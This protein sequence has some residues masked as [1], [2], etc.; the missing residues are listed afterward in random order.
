[1]WGMD[2]LFSKG[3]RSLQLFVAVP[4]GLAFIIPSLSN[5]PPFRADR[6]EELVVAVFEQME[7]GDKF[8]IHEMSGWSWVFYAR[9]IPRGNVRYGRCRRGDPR[10]QLQDLD[11]FRGEARVWVL[12]GRILPNF[13]PETETNLDYLRTIGFQAQTISVE[14]TGPLEYTAFLFRLNDED[15]LGRADSETFPVGEPVEVPAHLIC[16]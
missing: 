3:S 11:R 16:R 6:Y 12:F 1:M 10:A 8:L 4:L 9:G 13:R 5:P 2:F 14:G 7:E 15:R